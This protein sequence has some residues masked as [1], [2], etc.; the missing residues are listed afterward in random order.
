MRPPFVFSFVL[1][2]PGVVFYS[3][4]FEFVD[5]QCMNWGFLRKSRLKNVLELLVR[6]VVK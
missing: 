6:L 5:L 4:L 1:L 3:F 2:F